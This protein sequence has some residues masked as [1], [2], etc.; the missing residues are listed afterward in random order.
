MKK[1]LTSS[2]YA[3]SAAAGVLALSAGAASAQGENVSASMG[4][5][6]NS[7]FVSYGADVWGGGDD[8]FS[9]RSTMFAWADVAFD[10]D[11]VVVN[12]GLWFD[13][14]NNAP[15]S[16]GGNFQEIDWYVGA[17]YAAGIFSLGA[18]YQEWNY[19]G[20]VE[21]IV[22]L[23]VAWDDSSYMGDF[24]LAP[25]LTWHIRV[26]GN[27]GQD[28]GSAVVFAIAPSAPLSGPVTLAFPIG[29]GLFLSDDFQGG[30]ESGLAYGYAGASLGV[31]L[32]EAGPYGA[33]TLTADAIYYSTD[34]D[35]I[36]GNVAGG[37]LTGAVGIKVAF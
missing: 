3:V 30:T 16:I 4:T 14:N 9:S 10:F 36:P 19:A 24:T 22:D 18:T 21:R 37:F 20:D 25:S 15:S 5:S 6:Y 35:A 31:P 17:T 12:G 1:L 28:E 2:A 11:P 29:V 34:G 33:W 8:I 23:K 27:G 13:I 7:H 26:D 32:G